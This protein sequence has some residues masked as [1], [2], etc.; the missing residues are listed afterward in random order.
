MSVGSCSFRGFSVIVVT[1]NG[2]KR[3]VVPAAAPPQMTGTLEILEGKVGPLER[4]HLAGVG[5]PAPHDHV[6]ISGLVFDAARLAAGLFSRDQRAAAAGKGIEH[7]RAAPCDVPDRFCQHGD[8][9]DGR[10]H[11]ELVKPAGPEGI[12]P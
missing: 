3:T 7:E 10:V 11:G 8:R 5:L 2:W 9:L 6:A 12:D 4:S 1:P